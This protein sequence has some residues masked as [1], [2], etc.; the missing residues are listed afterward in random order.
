M[1]FSCGTLSFLCLRLALC[2]VCSQ[3]WPWIPGLPASASWVLCFAQPLWAAIVWARPSHYLLLPSLVCVCLPSPC[4]FF[5][6]LFRLCARLSMCSCSH[7]LLGSVSLSSF[8]GP[9]PVN[10]FNTLDTEH[11]NVLQKEHRSYTHSYGSCAHH[12]IS[13]SI[14]DN[15]LDEWCR[16]IHSSVPLMSRKPDVRLSAPWSVLFLL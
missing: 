12:P 8:I 3:G 6:K 15:S 14:L 1:V 11:Q 5:F 7:I 4:F 10:V 13:L 16:L 9:K 2:S